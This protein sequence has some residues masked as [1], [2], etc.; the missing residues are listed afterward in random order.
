MTDQ[1]THPAAEHTTN[2][3]SGRAIQSAAEHT[4]NPE[5]GQAIHTAADQAVDP[6][7]GRATIPVRLRR[8]VT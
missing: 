2:S 8:A 5:S 7:A 1:S 4:T 6:A 3:E